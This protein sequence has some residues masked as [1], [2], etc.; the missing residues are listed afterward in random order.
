MELKD[1]LQDYTESEFYRLLEDFFEDTDTNDLP[2][3]EY[4]KHISKL[5]EHFA[6][7][8]DHPEGNGLIF[9]PVAGRED[10]PRGVIEEI[11]NWYKAQG[12]Q[13]FKN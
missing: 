5:A 2:N 4:D 13:C 10:S 6:N 7:I 12:K 1:Q 9:H 11:K 8:V 3:T